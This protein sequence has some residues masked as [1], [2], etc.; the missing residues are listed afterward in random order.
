MTYDTTLHFYNLA[1][2]T[3]QMTVVS[4]IDEPFL[5]MPDDLLVN[6]HERRD[7]IVSLL[8]KLP[9]M[10]AGSQATEVALG[11]ALK[12]AYALAQH[13]GGKVRAYAASSPRGLAAALLN[14]ES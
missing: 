2:S 13:I 3:P 14:A 6:A 8:E 9:A 12:A 5:P 1:A 11:P 10:F 4:E 7:S